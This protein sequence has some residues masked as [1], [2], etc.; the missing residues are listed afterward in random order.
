M[1][2]GYQTTDTNIIINKTDHKRSS[3]EMKQ[4]T[5]NLQAV[6]VGQKSGKQLLWMDVVNDC[7]WKDNCS[8]QPP[9]ITNKQTTTKPRHFLNMEGEI[10][11]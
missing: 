6:R 7:P 1:L 8:T 5:F 4:R 9:N 11:K 3:F 2:H 10:K